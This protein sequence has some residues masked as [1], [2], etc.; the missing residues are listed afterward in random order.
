[1]HRR[2][3]LKRKAHRKR[4]PRMSPWSSCDS[5][6][7]IFQRRYRTHA[8]SPLKT[9]HYTGY[10]PKKQYP[11]GRASQFCSR[12]F[13]VMPAAVQHQ[14]YRCRAYANTLLVFAMNVV[15]RFINGLL[16]P[17]ILALSDA[18]L[19]RFFTLPRLFR[20]GFQLIGFLRSAGSPEERKALQRSLSLSKV[21]SSSTRVIHQIYIYSFSVVLTPAPTIVNTWLEPSDELPAIL[22][23]AVFVI[24]H[25]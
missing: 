2:Y 14:S 19:T 1:M 11:H 8:S 22:R 20:A 5:D 17:V 18:W 7:P 10:H 3:C 6:A 24:K 13:S 25:R 23:N 15:I 16:C 4:S 21:R 12:G 9:P